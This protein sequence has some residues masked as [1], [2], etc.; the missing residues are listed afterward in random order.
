MKLCIQK[1]LIKYITY[2]DKH[3]LK[4][5]NMIVYYYLYFDLLVKLMDLMKIFFITFTIL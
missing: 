4:I 1:I 2:C 3:S 5:C